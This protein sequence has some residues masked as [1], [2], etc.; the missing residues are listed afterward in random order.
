MEWFAKWH[1]DHAKERKKEKR[2][3]IDENEP[4][5]RSTVSYRS[6]E[7]LGVLGASLESISPEKKM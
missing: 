1:L 5:R 3:G 6:H 2:S 7:P 4:K